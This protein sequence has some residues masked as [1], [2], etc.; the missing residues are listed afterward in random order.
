MTAPAAALRLRA[1][2]TFPGGAA[3]GTSEPFDVGIAPPTNL[4]FIQQPTTTAVATPIAPP[5]RVRVLDN[6][7]AVIPGVF[8]NMT[9]L[10]APEGVV[11]SGSVNAV[12]NVEGIASF[13]NLAVKRAGGRLRLRAQAT[14]PGGSETGTSEPFDI[15]VVPAAV[16]ITEHSFIYDGAPKP[17]AVSTD[18]PELSVDVTYNGGEVVPAAIGAY[19]ALATNQR[20][21]VFRLGIGG[22]DDCIDGLGWR[23]WRQP[24]RARLLAGRVRQRCQP[25]DQPVLRSARS[26][27]AL[28]R[29]R[30]RPPVCRSATGRRGCVHRGSAVVPAPAT[31]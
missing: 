25:L 8:V 10:N 5:V 3:A 6:T 18:P 13:A 28:Q 12:A 21:R 9:L 14:F 30:A 19:L 27:A 20:A 7:G 31:S 4:F 24:V 11:L 2:A 22:A 17:V 1:T 29:H 26:A 23:I 15:G 16:T